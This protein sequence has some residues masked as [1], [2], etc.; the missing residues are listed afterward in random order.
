MSRTKRLTSAFAV[1][2]VAASILTFA[3]APASAAPAAPSGA[4]CDGQWHQTKDFI[5]S[6]VSG[7]IP[8]TPG[9]DFTRDIQYRA[10]SGVTAVHGSP[11]TP[12]ACTYVTK[13]FATAAQYRYKICRSTIACEETEFQNY[14]GNTPSPGWRFP[15]KVVGYDINANQWRPYADV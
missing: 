7:W 10:L 6:W 8:S 2:G 13:N 3:G 12:P 14:Q 4:P 11:G 1:A 9:V 5:G 15:G